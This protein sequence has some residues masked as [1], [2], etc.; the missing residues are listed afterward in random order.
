[1]G[2]KSSPGDPGKR[3]KQRQKDMDATW[4]ERE[5]MQRNQAKAKEQELASD[6]EKMPEVDDE[7][8]W[9]L[10]KIDRTKFYAAALVHDC[11]DSQRSWCEQVPD[12]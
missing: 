9:S 10:A 6:S 11:I 5:K 3:S 8:I 1:M 4:R 7:E 2:R 12:A